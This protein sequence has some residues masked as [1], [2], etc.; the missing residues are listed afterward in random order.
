MNPQQASQ[1]ARDLRETIERHNHL[2]YVVGKPEISD[3]EYDRLYRELAD[4]EQAFPELADP[5]SP[6]RRVGGEPL[7]GFRSVTHAKPMLSLDNT[8]S[9]ED[10]AAFDARVRK[11]AAGAPLTYVVEPK[12]DGL[13][14]SLRY[15]R[16]VFVLG[17]TRGDGRHGDDITANLRTIRGV[18]GRLL[19]ARRPPA[20][21]EVR[22]EVFMPRAGFEA[23]NRRRAESGEEPFANSRNAAA[24][25]LKLLDPRQVAQR[26]LDVVL[27][28]VGELDGIAFETHL[29]LIEA[30]REFGFRTV[31]RAWACADL[32]AVLKALDDLRDLRRAFPF[33]TDGGVVKV[34]ERGLYDALGATTKSPRW[35]V[36]FK[37]EPDRVETRL[38]A[39]T[40]QVGRTGALTPV[41]ELEPVVLAGS[42]IAR[43]TLHNQEDIRRKDIRIGDVVVIEKAGDVIPAVVAAV[44]SRRTGAERPFQMPDRCPSCGGPV[45]AVADEVALR[46]ENL[47]CPAQ[48]KRWLRH[49]AARGAMDIEGLGDALVDQL[50]DSGLVRDPADLYTLEPSRL[51]ELERMAEKSA[52][53]LLAG[54]EASKHR[55]LWRLLFGLGIR[56][57]GARTAQLLEREFADLAEIESA[58]TD[59][60]ERIPELGPVVAASVVDFFCRS[61]TRTFLAR[62]RRA[63]VN[64]RRLADPAARTA[65][66]AGKTVVLTGALSSMTRDEAERRIRAL[67]GQTSG[68]VSAK[69]ALVVA[70]DAPGSK[71]AR[72]RALGVPVLDEPAFLDLLEGRT[73][74]PGGPA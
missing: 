55:D 64:T 30:L 2:Y 12:I 44:A 40:V 65:P 37:F 26:P 60:L 50:V 46:C 33:D 22:G 41:A 71:L 16:G 3:R 51:A 54:I 52:A 34:N 66:L 8:Y 43:A 72:A 73:S 15:E 14:V 11:L 62:L 36:A 63:G 10:L 29:D 7:E 48:R 32:A 74:L 61:D 38:R 67:G 45:A 70:G 58:A 17:A 23:L 25:S 53:N 57:V 27:Y 13:A 47:Q 59:R 5:A 19:G 21:L 35:A 24:G 18:P 49:F 1:R 69:T 39:I 6:T 28:A 9:R 56:H 31:P 20:V 68:S 42:T 4:L